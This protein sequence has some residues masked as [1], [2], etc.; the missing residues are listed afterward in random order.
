MQSGSSASSSLW[1]AASSSLQMERAR[2]DI[3]SRA[4]LLTD[5]A[6]ATRAYTNHAVRPQL[7]Y[8]SEWT[9]AAVP[10]F[11]SRSVMEELLADPRYEDYQVREAALNPVND[12]NRAN[13]WEVT[14]IQ[15]F[16]AHADLNEVDGWRT[17]EGGDAMLYLA[18]PLRVTDETCL[19]CHGSV[20]EA[21]P[22]MVKKYGGDS[23]YNWE[24]GQLV[25]AQ[26]VTVPM[27]SAY[28]TA[29]HMTANVLVA[30][31]SI[32]AIMFLALNAIVGRRLLRPVAALLDTTRRYS[33]GEKSVAPAD[34]EADGELGELAR[35]VNRMRQSLD[36]ALDL[37][38]DE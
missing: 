13:A 5:F 9:D 31:V 24:I 2:H 38:R 28:I 27:S 19:N 10:S 34:E 26:V 35:S 7:D 23:G 22:G 3:L 33:L 29:L 12:L 37:L 17:L 30:L 4:Y 25:G 14:L 8:E 11:A 15:N 1:T 32:F 6:E 16:A 18:R 36:K 20:D 21:P